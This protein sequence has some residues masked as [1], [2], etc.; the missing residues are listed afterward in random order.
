MLEQANAKIRCWWGQ[1]LA[2]QGEMR[3]ALEDMQFAARLLGDDA[4]VA[5]AVGQVAE[6][7]DR[8]P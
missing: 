1:A 7:V 2:Q 3:R 6:K 8:R 4:K 5:F